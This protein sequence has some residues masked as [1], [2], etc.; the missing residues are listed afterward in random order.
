MAPDTQLLDQCR[1]F[2]AKAMK[3]F[4]G[5]DVC[6]LKVSDLRKLHALLNPEPDT[7]RIPVERIDATPYRLME[8]AAVER[9]QG[10]V[11]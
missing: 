6:A 11:S 1:E 3:R 9:M 5:H 4:D 7:Y 8:A 2:V 10:R